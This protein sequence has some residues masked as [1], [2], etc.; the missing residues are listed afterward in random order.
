MAE[1]AVPVLPLCLS[2]SAGAMLYVV[3]QELLPALEEGKCRRVGTL[4]FCAGFTVMM[5]MDVA[6]G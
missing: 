1:L 4:L 6:L 3:A 2:F 5:A